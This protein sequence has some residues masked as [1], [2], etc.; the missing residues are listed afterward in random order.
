MN[1]WATG[2]CMRRTGTF[3]ATI[4]LTHFLS[5]AEAAPSPTTF[6]VHWSVGSLSPYRAAGLRAG[7]AA[8]LVPATV[9]AAWPS[10]RRAVGPPPPPSAATSACAPTEP[11]TEV[12]P[13]PRAPRRPSRAAAARRAPA[14]APPPRAREAGVHVA[15]SGV[16]RRRRRRG[17]HHALYYEAAVLGG[18]RACTDALVPRRWA[19]DGGAE[20]ASR[21]SAAVC[22]RAAAASSSSSGAAPGGAG[23]LRG[24]ARPP[25]VAAHDGASRAGEDGTGGAGAPKRRAPRSARSTLRPVASTGSLRG[26]PARRHGAA[27]AAA[28]A[29]A[30]AAVVGGPRRDPASDSSGGVATLQRDPKG[31]S[32]SSGGVTTLQRDPKGSSDSSGGVSSA[33]QTGPP[34]RGWRRPRGA[35]VASAAGDGASTSSD[36]L[37]DAPLR[38]RDPSAIVGASADGAP[39]S[40]PVTAFCDSLTSTV[41]GAA[42]R[43]SPSLVGGNGEEGREDAGAASEDDLFRSLPAISPLGRPGVGDVERS[44]DAM[45][46]PALWKGGEPGGGGEGGVAPTF[47]PDLPS[48]GS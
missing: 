17:G 26:L 45:F 12:P 3:S 28:A 9:R 43:A 46:E 34:P 29:T 48:F 18:P 33:Q 2:H 14:V 38:T 27:A 6:N 5:G 21:V 24:V 47:G 37:E 44:W 10:T 35:A 22:S 32:D 13:P 31:S 41:F 36:G 15:T 1:H 8:H 23:P 25:R 20:E 7:L 19:A 40:S 30:A 16:G 39:R 4:S 11:R 42:P